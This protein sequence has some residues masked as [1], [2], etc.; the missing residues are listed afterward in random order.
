MKQVASLILL[1]ACNR[2][3]TAP[4]ISNNPI[5]NPT[6]E[7]RRG[8]LERGMANCPS[9]V[10]GARTELVMTE[11]G[12][13]LVITADDPDARRQILALAERHMR[14]GDPAGLPEHSGLHGGPGTMGYCP[15]IH[16]ATTIT[17]TRTQEGV[18]VHVR[19]LVPSKLKALQE[20][21]QSRVAGLQAHAEC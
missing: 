12:V 20:E 17:V 7:S 21:T 16:H 9:A 2:S 10:A 1:V 15:I 3:P 19:A 13:D 18:I 6:S 4:T 5:P 8:E 14:M 11:T